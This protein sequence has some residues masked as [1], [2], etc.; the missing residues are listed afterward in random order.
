MLLA[1]LGA[2]VVKVESPTGDPTR[3]WGPFRDDDPVR[4]FGGYFAS[5]N[6][7]KRS[8]CVDL[9]SASGREVLLSLLDGADVLVENFRVGVLDRLGFGWDLLH[10]RFP[11][12][13]LASISGFGHARTGA[14]PY[15][16]WPS[17]DVVAQA[18]GGLIGITGEAGGE[19]L[20]AG[21]GIGDIYPATLAAVG[22]LAAVHR[23][24]ASGV[25]DVVDVAMYDG[26]L[27]LCE[28]IIY[29]HS[30][31][32]ESPG[33]QGNDHP[34][35]CPYGLFP[36]ADGWVAI[37]APTDRHWELLVASMGEWGPRERPDL[38]TN[39]DRAAR[40]VEVRQLVAD[41]TGGRTTAAVLE[42]LGGRVPCSPV[43]RAEDIVADPHVA[44]RR[45]LVEVAHPGTGPVTI[46][47]T[48]IKFGSG[49]GV[50]TR[51]APLLGEHTVD[52]L[53]EHGWDAGKVGELVAAGVVRST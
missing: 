20:K 2:H 19:P 52:V 6:R 5:I 38:A 42:V 44:A 9:K 40:S 49:P 53:L 47:G 17:F 18:M 13:V 35:L 10:A 43:H 16:D 48:P 15:E 29:Q 36:T 23:A 4:A 25:G 1:D 34:L 33:L 32:G 24:Q 8:V 45:M 50:A 28:R 14:S 12:L 22:V 41:W 37:A 7:N 27:A 3:T 11:R 21:P 51:R 46:V 39:A 26:V 31:T 30:F